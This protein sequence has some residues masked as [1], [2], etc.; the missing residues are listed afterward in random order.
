MTAAEIKRQVEQ[1][2]RALYS[3]QQPSPDEIADD[4]IEHQSSAGFSFVG[5]CEYAATRIADHPEHELRVHRVLA[6][7]DKVFFHVEERLDEATR[8]ARGELFRVE[9]GVIAEHWGTE[10][11]VQPTL[12]HDNGMFDGPG[13]DLATNIGP[14]HLDDL[15][16]GYTRSFV[17]LDEQAFLDSSGSRMIQHNPEIPDGLGALPEFFDLLRANALSIDLDIK[18]ALAEGDFCV[19]YSYVNI[20]PFFPHIA[21]FDIFRLDE[22]GRKEEHWDVISALLSPQHFENSF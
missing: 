14:S 11:E 20:D 15:V 5:L 1:F 12:I 22:R 13:V 10:Q 2:Y 3:D 19:T 17:N 21:A 9:H 16:E 8:F 18:Q 6:Q 4:Y 7:D